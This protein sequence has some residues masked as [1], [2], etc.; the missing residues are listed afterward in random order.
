MAVKQKKPKANLAAEKVYGPIKSI[1]MSW[2]IKAVPQI[3]EHEI[4]QRRDIIF[5]FILFNIAN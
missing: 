1:P 5:L 3:N 2:A 4:A